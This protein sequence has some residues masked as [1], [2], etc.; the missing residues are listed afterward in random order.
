MKFITIPCNG[1]QNPLQDLCPTLMPNQSIFIN[2]HFCK[3]PTTVLASDFKSSKLNEAGDTD[4]YVGSSVNLLTA[5]VFS[6]LNTQGLSIA[7]IDYSIYGMVT[8]HVHPRAS[9]MLYVIDGIIIAGFVAKNKVF[10]QILKQGDVFVY[11]R[12]LLHFSVNA[13]FGPATSI[14]VFNCQN[15][16]VVSFSDGIFM[17][18]S[19]LLE[20]V[21]RRSFG[22]S[23]L[24]I[25]HARNVTRG[26]LSGTRNLQFSEV[27][28]ALVALS[29]E[30]KLRVCKISS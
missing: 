18:D 28:L 22:L 5:E 11:P 16:G 13:G 3:A 7:R 1:D 14:S 15:P 24:E 21:V 9:E 20:R 19:G 17:S 2:G 30:A 12:G 6:G 25:G 8:P 27:A 23:A 4:N 29:Q 10:Q 26:R